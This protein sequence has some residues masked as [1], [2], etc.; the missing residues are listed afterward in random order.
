MREKQIERARASM[1]KNTSK[2]MLR[3]GTSW[4]LGSILVTA[5]SRR[6][7]SSS[8]FMDLASDQEKYSQEI[9]Q[10]HVP[11]FQTNFYKTKFSSLVMAVQTVNGQHS[12]IVQVPATPLPH[13]VTL[14]KL[15]SVLQFLHPEDVLVLYISCEN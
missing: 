5:S 7:K 8:S 12:S 14:G 3:D 6:Y 9:N 4:L 1:G 10:I 13:C 15:L 11:Y 2:W